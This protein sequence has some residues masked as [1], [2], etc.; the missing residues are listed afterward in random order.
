VLVG[1]M[2]VILLAVSTLIVLLVTP[3]L[4]VNMAQQ[5]LGVLG[6]GVRGLAALIAW[7][8]SFLPQTTAPPESALPAGGIG[9]LPSPMTAP[10]SHVDVPPSW[11]FEIFLTLVGVIVLSLGIRVVL[12]W[13]PKRLFVWQR[14]PRE[15]GPPVSDAPDFAWNS[16]WRTLL[17]WF[18]AW[19][20][21]PRAASA[22][23][24]RGGATASGAAP[25]E[26]RSIR[27]LYRELL[28]AAERAGFDRS[29]ATTPAELA[30]S[31]TR[32]RPDVQAPVSALT[33]LYVR[34]RYGEETAGRDE[35]NRMRSAV[36]RVR[37]ELARAD[38]DADRARH[39]GASGSDRSGTHPT[40]R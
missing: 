7:I 25:R 5:A 15:P 27:A 30:G 6:F 3:E 19:V 12:R 33:E 21:G 17:A 23:A 14:P 4:I 22:G 26:Q 11:I 24:R 32:A 20:R 37:Q 31:M 29:P 36:E 1:V 34:T 9:A 40:E 16:W 38:R 8:G 35:V 18:A 13:A 28:S 10:A 2:M 39:G